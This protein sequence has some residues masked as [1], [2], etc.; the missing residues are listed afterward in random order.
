MKR[1]FKRTTH[2]RHGLP[3]FDNL[4]KKQFIA[5]YPEQIWMTDIT[6]IWTGEGWLY[7]A[8]V[9]DLYS[10]K[11]VG[12]N[13]SHRLTK[14]LVIKA[15]LQAVRK[16]NPRRGIILH[17][18]RGS[19]YASNDY[20][21]TAKKYGFIQSMSGKGNCYDNAVVESFFHTLKTEYVFWEKF[22][23][24]NQAVKSLFAYIEIFYNRFRK[25]SALGYKSPV[26]FEKCL[27][28]FIA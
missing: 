6:Y 23:T 11:I 10:R 27:R 2:S 28:V 3:V 12:W 25:H 20:K 19:Q 16:Y 8:I 26:D 1:K 7:L 18:D 17:S 22:E 15:L 13:M 4:I 14:E 21:S 24:R 9:L 5:E